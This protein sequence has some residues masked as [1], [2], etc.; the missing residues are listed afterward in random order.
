MHEIKEQIFHICAPFLDWCTSL[1][2]IGLFLLAF[3]E[4]SF[5]PIPPDF[6]YIPMILNGAVNPYTLAAVATCGSA[7]GAVLGYYIG[8]LGGRPI[9]KLVL[10]K[11]GEALI[12][13]AEDFFSKY[14]SAAVLIAA[15]T[16]IPFKV[17]TI[18]GGM[19]KMNLFGF[20]AYS[21]LGRG[22]RFF[23][24]TFLLVQFGEVIMENFFKLSLIVVL[25]SVAGYFGYK[26]FFE[27]PKAA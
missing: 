10:R 12:E 2:E 25:A 6:L 16:P 14:G 11:H 5:F 15:F 7:L 13:R 23:T 27:K 26:F 20:I 8:Y 17:F 18:A 4:S 1:G 24:V 22:A 9:A 3:I 21:I 19:S